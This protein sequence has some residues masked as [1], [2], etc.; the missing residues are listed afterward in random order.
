MKL[1]YL[2]FKH[3]LNTKYITKD[4]KEEKLNHDLFLTALI[5]Q[6]IA[7][8]KE[9]V[10]LLLHCVPVSICFVSIVMKFLISK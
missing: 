7:F 1:R 2:Y 10:K 3:I 4:I 5:K 6:L 9:C 8:L